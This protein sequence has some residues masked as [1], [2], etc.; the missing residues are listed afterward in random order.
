MEEYLQSACPRICLQRSVPLPRMLGWD[1]WGLLTSRCD[2]LNHITPLVA[3]Y[4]RGSSSHFLLVWLFSRST[5]DTQATARRPQ[6]AREPT[7]CN[8]PSP[9]RVEPLR[10]DLP[11]LGDHRRSLKSHG[12]ARTVWWC[13]CTAAFFFCRLALR[14]SG[15]S[16]QQAPVTE[17]LKFWNYTVIIY[18]F[19]FQIVLCTIF[20]TQI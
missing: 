6:G 19:S 3:K 11:H 8:F 14:R 20:E 13:S 2:T 16:F 12:S 15:R 7:W 1:L 4:L 18:I 9:G 10:A 5:Q 17:S